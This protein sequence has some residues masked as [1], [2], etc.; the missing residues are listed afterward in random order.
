[1]WI[2]ENAV[3]GYNDESH[4][5]SYW[6]YYH[7]SSLDTCSVDI[8]LLLTLSSW[9]S[10]FINFLIR[11]KKKMLMFL[12]GTILMSVKWR[13]FFF[14]LYI[15]S[16]SFGILRFSQH[17][18]LFILNR[19]SLL[20]S[21]TP[22]SFPFSSHIPVCFSITHF[23]HIYPIPVCFFITHYYHFYPIPVC[24]LIPFTPISISRTLTIRNASRPAVW[25]VSNTLSLPRF[26][27]KSPY[28]GR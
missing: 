4:R 20:L 16:V 10:Y 5:C 28:L 11:K 6:Y 25:V 9:L 1:M 17:H 24:F 19:A 22:A 2:Q 13:V 27:P 12:S 15:S 8:I 14:L 18:L 3:Y 7:Y 21:I 26:P 23:Y